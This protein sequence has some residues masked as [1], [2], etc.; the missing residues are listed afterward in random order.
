MGSKSLSYFQSLTSSELRSILESKN[1]SRENKEKASE[2]LKLLEGRR[3]RTP[4]DNPIERERR[5]TI[6]TR[7]SSLNDAPPMGKRAF[8]RDE[9]EWELRHEDEADG[10]Y[11]K[12][13]NSWRKRKSSPTSSLTDVTKKEAE[14]NQELT[15]SEQ[16]MFDKIKD[17]Y[18]AQGKSEEDIK[19]IAKGIL[20]KR[21]KK[22]ESKVRES[23]DNI[24]FGSLDG[25]VDDAYY[26]DEYDDEDEERITDISDDPEKDE[27]YWKAYN[28]REMA[29]LNEPEEEE[30]N[31]D[32]NWW[33]ESFKTRKRKNRLVEHT[34]LE[35]R[36]ER[37]K[38]DKSYSALA[39]VLEYLAADLNKRAEAQGTSFSKEDT[40]EIITEAIDLI[41]GGDDISVDELTARLETLLDFGD[42]DVEVI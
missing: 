1:I 42:P 14:K 5:R 25:S 3:W 9:L 35:S 40:D 41:A 32:K 26:E 19:R 36:L 39:E 8:K 23:F 12:Y 2:V 15:D 38:G 29:R 33:E 10:N 37:F 20:R 30:D 17:R 21:S 6:G 31:E 4:A 16:K 22:Q 24:I 27:A 11:N 18:L 28:D 7:R 34:E 13:S